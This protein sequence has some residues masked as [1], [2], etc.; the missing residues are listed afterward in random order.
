MDGR[1]PVWAGLR[2]PAVV[3]GTVALVLL[4]GSRP[5]DLVVDPFLGSGTTAV[6]A[7]RPRYSATAGL[8]MPRASHAV[9]AIVR[10][11]TRTRLPRGSRRISR[12]RSEAGPNLYRAGYAR[13]P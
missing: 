4:A 1:E 8:T 10:T 7:R 13:E 9:R 6:V 11:A 2:L 12:S 3:W 5:G